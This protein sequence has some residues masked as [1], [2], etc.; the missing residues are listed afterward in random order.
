MTANARVGRPAPE[1][2]AEEYLLRRAAL[3]LQQSERQ[4]VEAVCEAASNGVCWERIEELLG[5]SAPR[6]RAIY[7]ALIEQAS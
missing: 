5:D 1:I 2:R 3:D 4:L 7:G 6:A